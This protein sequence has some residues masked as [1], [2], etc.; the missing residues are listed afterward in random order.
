MDWVE[1]LASLAASQERSVLLGGL[2]QDAPEQIHAGL[3]T[4]LYSD[5]AAASRLADA[6][7][8]LARMRRDPQS[9]AFAARSAAHILHLKG[10]H[11]AAVQN[12][13]KAVSLFEQ[14]GETG[15][16]GRTLSSGL[17][18]LAYLG[19]YEEAH[20]WANR[21]EQIFLAQG[22][23]LR[24]A[25]LD[26]N[27][28]NLYFRQDRPREALVRYQRAL[29]GFEGTGLATDTVAVL[30]NLAVCE[31]NVG[32]FPAALDCYRRAR[33]HAGEQ[34]LA[35][36]RLRRTTT[37]RFYITSAATTGKHGV[38]TSFRG[39]AAE[40]PEMPI[41]TPSAIWTRRRWTWS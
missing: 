38:C 19:R 33:Q 14:E 36:W 21:A 2:P 1:Q 17:Q 26:S 39:S 8:E 16:V 32:N 40:S 24:L 31:T 7:Q 5:L 34:G 28:G 15:E 22:D 4:R 9:V 12:Y 20:Q 10:S 37:L 18:A 11:D 30:S 13:R 29:D 25:R 6:C 23:V 27:V 41:M 35:V 3:L